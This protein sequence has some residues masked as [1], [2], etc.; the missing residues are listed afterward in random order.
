MKR[1]KIYTLRRCIFPNCVRPVRARG[2]CHPHWLSERRKEIWESELN[3][4]D[5]EKTRF[6]FK[7]MLHRHIR[8][9]GYITPCWDWAGPRNPGGYGAINFKHIRILI[10][11]VAA[12]L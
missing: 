3:F 9:H 11:R 8:D 1:I 5:V 4:S 2:M 12:Y 7:L 10:H 6:F